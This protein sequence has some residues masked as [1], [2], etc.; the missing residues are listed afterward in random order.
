MEPTS[1][2][3]DRLF[4]DKVEQARRMSDEEKLMAGPRLFD[5]VCRVMVDGIRDQFPDA[6]EEQ[7]QQILRDRL[8]IAKR[9]ESTPFE[10]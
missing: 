6:T 8:A 5:R 2:L 4:L 3:L 10:Q 7:V 1:E 9:L